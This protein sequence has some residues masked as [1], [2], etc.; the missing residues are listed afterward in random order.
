MNKSKWAAIPATLLLAMLA[1]NPVKASAQTAPE[2][3]LTTIPAEEEL[4]WPRVIKNAAETLTV[5]Q[6]QIEEWTGIQISTPRRGLRAALR[7]QPADL[8]RRLDE[9]PRRRGQSRARRDVPRFR[10]HQSRI[11]HGA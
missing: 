6:P 7:R 11:S 3:A 8:R 10:D 5:Y 9:G 2:N 4:T 1:I